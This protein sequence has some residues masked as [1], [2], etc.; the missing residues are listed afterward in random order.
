MQNLNLVGKRTHFLLQTMG[1]EKVVSAHSLTGLEVSGLGSNAFYE[2]PEILTQERMP[3]TT[4]N[5]VKEEDLVRWPYLSKVQIPHIMANVDLLIGCNA[6]KLLEPWEVIHSQGNGPY[7]I[8]TALGWVINGPTEDGKSNLDS[9][10]PPTVVNRISVCKLEEMLK[11][12]YNYDF[13]EKVTEEKG[14][15]REDLKFMK[16]ME[17]SA[18]MEDGHYCLKLPFKKDKIKMPNNFSIVKQRLHKYKNFMDEM[19]SNGYAEQIPSQQLS[20]EN[21]KKWYIPH[22]AV[23]HSRK[24]SIRIV[25]D[26]GAS[27]QGT[28]LNKQ[29]LQGPNLTSTLLGVLLRF[30][31]DP[32]PFIGDIKRLS[33]L[34]VV[35]R[36]RSEQEHN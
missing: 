19:L 35:A 14:L 34:F 28:L 5:F 23:Y 24:R 30:R 15:S 31:Q 9:K 6:P 13:N 2:L 16:I 17:K 32:V 10:H 7:A 36:W 26:C 21:G 29:L 8:R 1:Q 3:V 4:D 22:H 27:F 25:F 18:T 12:Q 33:A 11:S 20:C